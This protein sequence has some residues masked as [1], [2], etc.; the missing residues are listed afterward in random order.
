MKSVGIITR[1]AGNI[2][3]LARS[4]NFLGFEPVVLN[5][6]EQVAPQDAVILPGV[7]H[8]RAGANAL[9]SGFREPLM[10]HLRAGKPL[11]GICLGM[12]LMF[13]SSQEAP[14]LKGLGIFPGQVRL[15]QRATRLP[16]MGWNRIKMVE[17][18]DRLRS[19][20]GAWFYFAHSYVCPGPGVATTE[21]QSEEFPSVVIKDNAVGF[22][23]HPEKSGE[24]GLELLRRFLQ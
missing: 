13:S 7:G 19:W 10:E 20:D 8:F 21:Y 16:H 15:F 6:P 17:A 9:D 22:Q 3:S 11:I 1:G 2:F 24:R 14:D 18:E 4:L 12:Q 5:K 23:F